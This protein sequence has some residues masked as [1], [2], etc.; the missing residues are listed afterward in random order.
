VIGVSGVLA[1]AGMWIWALCVFWLII[2]VFRKGTIIFRA[3]WRAFVFLY[4]EMPLRLITGRPQPGK[5]RINIA[6]LEKALTK[7]EKEIAAV[8]HPRP[9]SDDRHGTFSTPT[10]RFKITLGNLI[11]YQRIRGLRADGIV[12]ETTLR[13]MRK[14][15]LPYGCVVIVDVPAKPV[16]L[17]VAQ[18]SDE[19]IRHEDIRQAARQM[20][21]ERM[22]RR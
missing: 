7:I 9:I 21:N 17:T 14:D 3:A 13:A 4:W 12:G 8:D 6:G 19:R 10:S 2:E 22:R 1:E 20:I 18:R 11:E 5:V 15:G 16:T